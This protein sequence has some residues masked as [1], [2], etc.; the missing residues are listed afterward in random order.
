MSLRIR[1]ASFLW[2]ISI[3]ALKTQVAA[4]KLLENS[5]ENHILLQF[6]Q[7]IRQST[8]PVTDVWSK[9]SIHEFKVFASCP[10]QI[11][12]IASFQLEFLI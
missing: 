8:G 10:E 4:S 2:S 11:G 5:S 12:R 3:R 7:S 9:Q 1:S 6:K